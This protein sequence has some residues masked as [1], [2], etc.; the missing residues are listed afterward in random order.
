MIVNTSLQE[1]SQDQAGEKESEREREK[2]RKGRQTDWELK[3]GKF[4]EGR[5][6]V[7]VEIRKKFQ[8]EKERVS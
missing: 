4:R 7:G 1:Y 5:E 3:L 8:G 6:R 2:E